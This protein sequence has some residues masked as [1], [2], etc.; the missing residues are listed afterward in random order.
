[1]ILRVRSFFNM[2]LCDSVGMMHPLHHSLSLDTD[3]LGSPSV[4]STRDHHA[5][6]IQLY[7]SLQSVEKHDSVKLC[8]TTVHTKDNWCTAHHNP[9]SS[10]NYRAVVLRSFQFHPLT[11]VLL[12]VLRLY[13]QSHF[14]GTLH[15]PLSVGLSS[16]LI[17]SPYSPQR[18]C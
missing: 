2:T 11:N 4:Q 5:R 14:C 1:M 17:C 10:T 18:P 7:L 12:V 13:N 16:H 3:Y 8:E 6:R 15:T 9:S